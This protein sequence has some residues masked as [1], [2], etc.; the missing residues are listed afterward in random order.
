MWSSLCPTWILP[1]KSR[2]EERPWPCL[3][4]T[5]EASRENHFATFRSLQCNGFLVVLIRS[6]LLGSC[7]LLLL[8]AAVLV[9]VV[10]LHLDT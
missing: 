6:F 4:H 8:V 1:S 10:V 7:L 5:G 2:P 9:D 3:L